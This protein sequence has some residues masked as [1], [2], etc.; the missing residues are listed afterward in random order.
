MSRYFFLAKADQIIRLSFH[1]NLANVSRHFPHL[2]WISSANLICNFC[3]YDLWK[4]CKSTSRKF[5]SHP[6]CG[7][8]QYD[9]FSQ[10]LTKPLRYNLYSEDDDEEEEEAVPDMKALTGSGGDLPQEFWQVT[11]SWSLHTPLHQG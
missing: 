11:A 5:F 8:Y 10:K 9:S 3:K 4:S 2:A 1:F 6:F 7:Y